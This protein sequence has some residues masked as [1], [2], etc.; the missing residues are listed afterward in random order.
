VHQRTA[1]AAGEH[2][3]VDL[4]GDVGLAEDQAAAGTAQGLVGGHGDHVGERQRRRHGTTGDQAR[5]MG[6]VGHQQAVRLVGDVGEGAVVDGAGVGA[7]AG[8]QDLGLV[9]LDEVAHLVEV[10]QAVPRVHAVLGRL[11]HLPRVAAV[12]AV[13]QMAARLQ[14]HADDAAAGTGERQQDGEVGRGTRVR[15]HVGLVGAGKQGQRPRPGHVLDDIGDL[16]AAVIAPAGIALGVLVG[17]AARDRFP[18]CR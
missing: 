16:T 5:R 12:V 8:D 13:G 4:L 17:D 9:A 18:D 7:A 10:D 6:D 3:R 1:L 2:G 15:L 14:R 11:E